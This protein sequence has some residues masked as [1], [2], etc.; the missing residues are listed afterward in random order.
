VIYDVL[1][2]QGSLSNIGPYSKELLRLHTF[3]T[4]LS[5]WLI[6]VIL[7]VRGAN[8]ESFFSLREGLFQLTQDSVGFAQPKLDD[9]IG[10]R[11]RIA[12]GIDAQLR[13][14]T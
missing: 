11:L 1:A 9:L 2:S 7:P 5:S 13:R 10:P 3:G 4:A 14:V 8:S 12:V 6:L